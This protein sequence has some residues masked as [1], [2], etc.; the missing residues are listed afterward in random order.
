MFK[1]P[2]FPHRIYIIELKRCKI[3]KFSTLLTEFSTFLL[4]N[5]DEY[6]LCTICC[7]YI[8]CIKNGI[9]NIKKAGKRVIRPGFLHTE[10]IK[11][12][13]TQSAPDRH[14]HRGTLFIFH[15][16]AFILEK[17]VNLVYSIPM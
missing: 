6:S 13:F 7:I 15:I 12:M 1:T 4:K 2:T 9:L 14:R 8:F 5:N 3:V 16:A 11:K 10:Y 17:F